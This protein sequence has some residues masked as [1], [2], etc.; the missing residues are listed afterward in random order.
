MAQ[1]TT[2]PRAI[3]SAPW[4]YDLAQNLVGANRSRARLV[5]DHL[6]LRPGMRL[7][8][9]GCGTAAM[10]HHLP[11]DVAYVGVDLS[12]SYIESARREFG[13]RGEFHCG[14][15]ARTAPD[16]F[17]TFDVVVANGLLHHLDDG[18]V[19]NMLRV[20]RTVLRAGGHLVTIDPCFDPGQSR[21]A[22]LVIT[23]DRG[24]NVRTLAGYAELA[25][26]MFTTVEP[27]LR[28]DMLRIPYT[29]AVLECRP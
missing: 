8:D 23:H 6:R 22:R 25:R 2:G 9:L 7:L 28:D 3:F 4:V 17:G 13:A 21:L 24:R 12:E 26:E 10:L 20:A 18:P 14:D 27:R 1:I 19:R 16:V 5:R 15:I 29:H 11:R